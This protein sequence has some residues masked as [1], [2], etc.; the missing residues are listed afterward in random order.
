MAFRLPDNSAGPGAAQQLL[1]VHL[2]RAKET[3]A[4]FNDATGPGYVQGSPVKTD[5]HPEFGLVGGRGPFREARN[6]P[7]NKHYFT[8]F[9]LD[10]DQFNRQG[11]T[12][13][14]FA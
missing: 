7:G 3:H 14:D 10:L 11:A 9:A 12:G 6:D 2:G 5:E 13:E 4:K 8:N 1:S